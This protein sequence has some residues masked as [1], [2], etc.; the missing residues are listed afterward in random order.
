M[1]RGGR[2]SPSSKKR[3]NDLRRRREV[4]EAVFRR[5]GGCILRNKSWGPCYGDLTLHHLLK[6]SQGG[7]YTEANLVALC[8]HHNNAVE[9]FPEAAHSLGLVIKSWEAK[10]ANPDAAHG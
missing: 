8:S 6:A 3:V 4:R 5:D 10:N 9:D 7:A 1:K 2:M